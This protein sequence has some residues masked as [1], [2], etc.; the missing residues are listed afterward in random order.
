MTSTA[1]PPRDLAPEPARATWIPLAIAALVAVAGLVA[2]LAVRA[3]LPDVVA[4]HWGPSGR[5]DGFS[6]VTGSIGFALVL[7]A[8]TSIGLT[9][10]GRALHAARDM[11]P[12]TSGAAVFLGGTVWGS[13]LA[14]RQGSSASIDGLLL[15]SGVAGVV[16]GALVWLVVRRR[17]SDLPE[18]HSGGLPAGA[19][20]LDVPEGARLAWTGRTRVSRGVVIFSIV[21]L[22]PLVVLTVWLA[23]AG[24]T[25]VAV[26]VGVLLVV[27][28]A[29]LAGMAGPVTVDARGVTASGFGFIRWVHVPLET[30]ESAGVQTIEYPLGEYR[31]YGRRRGV[32]GS[33][34]LVTSAGPA[35]RLERARDTPVVITVDDPARAAAVVNTLI[36][37]RG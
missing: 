14:Q 19:P 13:I 11:A 35:L 5:P 28:I 29:L 25:G 23:V 34:A 22:V 7:L 8:A 18:A 30:I 10:V 15:G 6:S 32:D 2:V 1:T 20:T 16:V 4:T 26:F 36:Q 37:R 3:E 9:L 12:A 27:L 24:G 21:T 33:V 17:D 31:G